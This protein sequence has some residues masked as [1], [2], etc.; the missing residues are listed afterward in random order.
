MKVFFG[1]ILLYYFF[2]V[3][4][5]LTLYTGFSASVITWMNIIVITIVTLLY[6]HCKTHEAS[7][8]QIKKVLLSVYARLRNI[9]EKYLF[10]LALI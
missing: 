8:N 10:V 5:F 9:S 2:G 1:V 6:Y 7:R 3:Q 4:H